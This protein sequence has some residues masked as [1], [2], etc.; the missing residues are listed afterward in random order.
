LPAAVK[1]KH[2]RV[3]CEAKLLSC[4]GAVHPLDAFTPLATEDKPKPKPKQKAEQT[5]PGDGGQ[6]A[7]QETGGD[8]D[9]TASRNDA[10]AD[11][12]DDEDGGPLPQYV[13][14]ADLNAAGIVDNRTQLKRIVEVEGFPP[15]VMLSPNTRAWLVS[16]VRAWLATRPAAGG[17][18]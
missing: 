14:F 18:K 17:A 9:R 1:R 6:H 8:E 3:K 10:D 2:G 11:D 16:D 12:E 13:R 15:G 7:R 4:N 5:G